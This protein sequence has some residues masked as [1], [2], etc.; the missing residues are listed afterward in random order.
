MCLTAR[1]GWLVGWLASAGLGELVQLSCRE[2]A[3]TARCCRYPL[4]WNKSFGEII[5]S[6]KGKKR[7]GADDDD[8]ANDSAVLQRSPWEFYFNKSVLGRGESSV[9]YTHK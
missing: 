5:Q 2:V 9:V 4:G 6:S 3:A 8:D 1:A 7:V